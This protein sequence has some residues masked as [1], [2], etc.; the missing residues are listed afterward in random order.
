MLS[1]SGDRTQ[2][3]NLS[4]YRRDEQQQQHHEPRS[5]YGM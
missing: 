2:K 1:R 5:W 4:K 3:R